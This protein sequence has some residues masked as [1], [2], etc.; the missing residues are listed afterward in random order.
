MRTH[1]AERRRDGEA[2]FT[3]IEALV[4]MVI[5]MFGIA[6][7]ANLMVV[8][9][10]SNTVANHGTAASAVASAQMELIKSTPFN[11]LPAAVAGS[12]NTDVGPTGVCGVTPITNTFNCNQQV[13]GVGRIH[14]RWEIS[15]PLAA[16]GVPNTRFIQVQAQ[17]M[18][19]A[20]GVRSRAQFTSFRTL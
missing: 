19:A 1:S 8:A 10:S 17:S 15:V 2:G 13:V 18:A 12:L 9:G 3:L 16:N 5:L 6:A 7:V 14:V 20:I 4:A 11:N